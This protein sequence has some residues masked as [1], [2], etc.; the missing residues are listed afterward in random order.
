[1][2]S[3]KSSGYF[4][5]LFGLGVLDC[6]S[7]IPL[8]SVQLG[9]VQIKKAW[10]PNNRG[11]PGPQVSFFICLPLLFFPSFMSCG[12]SGMSSFIFQR[13]Q[14]YS[15][16]FSLWKQPSEYNIC[17]ILVLQ[18]PQTLSHVLLAWFGEESWEERQK[19]AH[20]QVSHVDLMSLVC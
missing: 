4:S 15:D 16:L 2:E 8:R 18:K 19:T 12:L 17:W 6:H 3:H 5:A 11:S 13:R 1:M 14:W 9:A 20:M 10:V 7:Q